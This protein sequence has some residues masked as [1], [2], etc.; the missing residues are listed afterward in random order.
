MANRTTTETDIPATLQSIQ[1]CLEHLEE[2][3]AD[4]QKSMYGLLRRSTSLQQAKDERRASHKPR[5][6]K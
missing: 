5:R 1:G 6:K 4:L 2:M 3:M